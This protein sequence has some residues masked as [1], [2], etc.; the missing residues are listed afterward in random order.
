MKPSVC[1]PV[2]TPL[3]PII[4]F[5][6][7]ASMVHVCVIEIQVYIITLGVLKLYITCVIL[8]VSLCKLNVL[9]VLFCLKLCIF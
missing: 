1:L 3:P 4:Q 9:G 5:L 6:I 7:L 2:P 8:Y